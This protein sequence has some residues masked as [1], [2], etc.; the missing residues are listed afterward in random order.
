M[1]RYDVELTV[2]LR[3]APG[4]TEQEFVLL[5]ADGE[6]AAGSTVPDPRAALAAVEQYGEEIFFPV[7]RPD[8]RCTQ[9]Y[10]GPQTATVT[11]TFRGNRVDCRF[12]RTDGCEIAKWRSMAP[13]LGGVAGSTGAI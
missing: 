1:S 5:A 7:P 9:V 8:R 11:G 2:T 12:S 4:A 13:L 10:G 3:E 6:P